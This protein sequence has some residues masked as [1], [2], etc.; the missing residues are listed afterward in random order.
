MYFIEYQIIGGIQPDNRYYGTCIYNFYKN[1]LCGGGLFC[2][3]NYRLKSCL[4][5]GW[6]FVGS[7]ETLLLV[8]QDK[9]WDILKQYKWN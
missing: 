7:K 9:L 8:F 3:M 2:I 5:I 1:L 6:D 4:Q